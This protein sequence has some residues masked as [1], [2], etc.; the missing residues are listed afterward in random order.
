MRIVV[1]GSTGHVGTFLVPRLVQSG[2]QVISLSRGK[3]K[4]YQPHGAW[5]QVEKIICDRDREEQEGTFGPMIADLKPDAVIDMICFTPESARH[6]IHALREK[7]GHLLFCGT[8]W[9]HGYSITVP[10]S[11]DENINPFG[12]YG[13]QKARMRTYLLQEAKN[14]QLPV[15]ILHP[16]HIVG[17][18]WNPVNPVGNFNPNVFSILARGEILR[19]PTLGLESVHHVHADDVAQAFVKAL[20]NWNKAAGEDFH[21]V[22]DAAITLRGFAE[23]VAS[24]FERKS[25]LQFSAGEEWKTGFSDED[26]DASWDHILH[27]PNCSIEKAKTSIGYR[28]RYTSLEAVHESLEW[29]IEKK[30]VSGNLKRNTEHFSSKGFPG[31]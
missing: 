22:S 25:H 3:R 8:I 6:L 17:P 2:Y 26:I 18:G 15:S 24:W 1:I 4:P 29:L 30:V 10:T 20:Q 21:V 19:Y 9:I 7:V 13:I 11:E 27:S 28:P 23:T 12:E 16:G 31:R 5:E 14:H